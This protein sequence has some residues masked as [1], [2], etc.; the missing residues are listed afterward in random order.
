M[1]NQMKEQYLLSIIVTCHNEELYIKRCIESIVAEKNDS[2]EIIV[3]DDYSTDSSAEIIKQYGSIVNIITF[4]ENHGLSYSRNYGIKQAQGQYIM[5]LDG[6]DYLSEGVISDIISCLER[7]NPDVLFGLI[8]TFKETPNMINRWNEPTITDPHIF[9][10]LNNGELLLRLFHMKIKL[11]PAQR[12]IVHSQL[13]TD[14]HMEFENVYHEDELWTP[15]MLCYAKKICFLCRTMFFHM[16]KV[17]GLGS[18]FDE[19]NIESY[20]YILQ[21]L[22]AFTEE[23]NEPKKKSFVLQRCKYNVAKIKNKIEGWSQERQKLFLSQNGE[24]MRDV[25]QQIIRMLESLASC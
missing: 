17:N 2:V 18:I 11:P 19:P 21:Q 13:I 5:F 25:E 6:D 9:D 24:K 3:I 16:I 8:E 22:V 10:G 1:V 20:I 4:H 15:K 14:Y 23:L 12:Y 7:E